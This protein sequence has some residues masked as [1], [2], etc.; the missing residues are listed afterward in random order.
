MIHTYIHTKIYN[1][2]HSQAYVARITG[3]EIYRRGYIPISPRR[4]A[5]DVCGSM[6]RSTADV[7]QPTVARARDL[8]QTSRIMRFGPQESCFQHLS[9]YFSRCCVNNGSYLGK[10]TP[11]CC[12][13]LSSVTSIT[14]H[15]ITIPQRHG[16]TDGRTTCRDK[17]RSA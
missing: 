17:P 12:F 4:Y 15:L 2:Q 6:V 10:I 13:C 9:Q 8:R 3:A 14:T 16:R 7:D 11:E 5:P 1:A